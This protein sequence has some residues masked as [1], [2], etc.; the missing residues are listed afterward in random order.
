MK[1]FLL[2]L[3]MSAALI[4]GA[5]SDNSENDELPELSGI[6]VLNEG[7]FGQ[8]N[9]SITSFNLST[10]SVSQNVFNSTNGRPLGDLLH[11][12]TRIDDKLYLVV[13]NSHKIEVVDPETFS[14]IATI[15]IADQASPR[16]MAKVGENKAYVTNL[17]GNTVS[18]IDLVTMTEAGTIAVGSNPEGIAVF[19]ERAYIANS[20]F[21]NGNTL[22]VIN[23]ATDQVIDEITVG[24]NPINLYI[25]ELDRLWVVCAGAYNDYSTPDDDTPGELY[26][27]NAE[28]GA[29][30]ASLE[31]GGH[32]GDLVLNAS[33][34]KG[35]ISNGGIYEVNTTN[36]TV[37]D[38]PIVNRSYYAIALT[39]TEEGEL[40]LWAADAGNFS[41]NG[42]AYRF[43]SEGTKVDSFATGIIPGGFYFNF[44]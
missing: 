3:L 31:V 18:I 11:S 42:M 4:F 28:T 25:D 38:N 22:S 37:S 9:A 34:G 33:A 39:T 19:G 16:F 5:C 23:T 35:Y 14:S 6:Y 24:D 41:Q 26:V 30:L 44:N 15:E 10:G 29:E 8:A 13:N 27:L 1:T 2:P 36:F 43:S 12:A 40:S 32:P 20:G 21:G 17:Y 7:N